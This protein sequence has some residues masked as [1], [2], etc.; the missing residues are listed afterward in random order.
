MKL[1]RVQEAITV[2]KASIDDEP[3]SKK[4]KSKVDVRAKKAKKVTKAKN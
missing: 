1:T 4:V 2:L 3:A